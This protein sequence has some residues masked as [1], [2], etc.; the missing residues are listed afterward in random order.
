MFPTY[1]GEV[2]LDV[3]VP[4]PVVE[5]VEGLAGGGGGE[6]QVVITRGGG[7]PHPVTQQR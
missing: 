6:H 5:A 7:A 4:V 3:P 2:P 1:P